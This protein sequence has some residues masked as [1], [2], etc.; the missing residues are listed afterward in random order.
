MQQDM[1]APSSSVLSNPQQQ[2]PQPGQGFQ[3]LPDS[4]QHDS[5][6]QQNQNPGGQ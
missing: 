4:G 5:G 6:Q 2:Q 3:T 1:P